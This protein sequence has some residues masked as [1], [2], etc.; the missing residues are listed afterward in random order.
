M[1]L[2]ILTKVEDI[3]AVC[4]YFASK[5]TGATVKEARAVVEKKHLD[6]R[7]INALKFWGLLEPDGDKLLITNLG[8]LAVRNNG[9]KLY[10]AL[11]Q[12]IR[13][14]PPYSAMVEKAFFNQEERNMSAGEV[15]A[16]WHRNF[17][18]QV[19]SDDRTLNYQVTCF[20]NIA[21]GANLG[22]LIRGR[23]GG[24][25]R[26]NFATEALNG[27]MGSSHP[28]EQ[29]ATPQ[30]IP[31]KVVEDIHPEQTKTE[32]N[33]AVKQGNRIFIVHG[34]NERILEQIKELLDHGKFEPVVAVE[35]ET[36]AVPVPQKI[37]EDMETCVGAVIQVSSE[38]ELKDEDGNMVPQ[39]N[40]N[41][42]IEIGAAMVLYEDRF[43]L[44]VQDGIELP[45]NL[46]GIYEC[47]YRGNELDGDAIMKLLK[48][49]LHLSSLTGHSG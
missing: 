16:H 40:T 5:P 2:P 13:N 43:I 35:H 21:E 41:V 3:V 33:R 34:K 30:D 15:A 11:L 48:A 14:I 31:P 32:T 44:L 27:F 10:E 38:R 36:T 6:G 29:D 19:A 4:S 42:L 47:R 7:K 20:F 45:S 22:K 24:E 1:S 46:Q 25:T 12:I 49:L 17:K 9:E 18:E 26:L 37:I 23:R 8:R 39:I 28:S